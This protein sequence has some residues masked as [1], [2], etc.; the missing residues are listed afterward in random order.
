MTVRLDMT[1]VEQTLV[2]VDCAAC[3]IQFAVPE[4]FDRKRQETGDSFWC[5]NGHSLSYK[6]ELAELR[7]KLV[8]KE[9]Q[10]TAANDQRR[11]AEQDADT[12]RRQ[13]A[14]ARGQVTR[15]KNRVGNGVCPCC[16]RTFRQLAAHMRTK[17][18]GYR[19]SG[20]AG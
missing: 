20:E 12:A 11:A 19:E 3:A 5:P 4:R 1:T 9:T 17:H 2:L 13:A 14:A 7:R 6:G 16:N 18:P 8:S 10:L 15:L